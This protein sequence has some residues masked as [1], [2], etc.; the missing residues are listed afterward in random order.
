[1][2]CQL[3]V[4]QELTQART[5]AISLARAITR[6]AGLRIRSGRTETFL[7]RLAALDLPASMKTTLSPLQ[8]V[9]EV[10]DD[11]L[12]SAD[13]QFAAMVAADPMVNR[14]TT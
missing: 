4:R 1:V 12:T 13:E 6:A 14:L 5:R 9:I 7:I 3:N 10:L 11:E 8:S 2:Q